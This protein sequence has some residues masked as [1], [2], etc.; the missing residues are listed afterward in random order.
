MKR[1]SRSF[2]WVLRSALLLGCAACYSPVGNAHC[3]TDAD[4][5]ASQSCVAGAC[6]AN[7]GAGGGGN[8]AGGGGAG[9]GTGGGI[10]GGAGGSGGGGVS[11]GGGGGAG[12]G[13]AGGAGGS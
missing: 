12:G 11:G 1:Q 5:P 10:A 8:G 3:T 13:T 4:C 2:S 9:G 7:T 6:H